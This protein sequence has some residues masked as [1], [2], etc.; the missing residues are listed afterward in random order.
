MQIGKI[1]KVKIRE[2]WKHEQYGF[3]EWLSI[4]ENL[5]ILS[6]KI[7]LSLVEPEKERFIGPYRCD[8]VCKDEETHRVVLIENQ[9]G[10]SNHDHLGKILTYAAG[11]DASAMI[12]IVEN[13]TE[14]HS[15]A[16]AWLN[17]HSDGDIGFYLIKIEAIKIDESSPAPNFIV[18]QQPNKFIEQIKESIKP[19]AGEKFIKTMGERLEFWSGFDKYVSSLSNLPFRKTKAT[20]NAWYNFTIG[21]SKCHIAVSMKK[22]KNFLRVGM[23]ID[24]KAKY[25]EFENNKEKIENA[26]GSALEWDPKPLKKASEIYI[27]VNNFKLGE[28]NTY[29]TLYKAVMDNVLKIYKSFKPFIK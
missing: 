19:E 18:I 4:Q 27:K 11:V 25:S 1:K 23:W 22:Q 12:W 13:P 2:L 17:K 24:D 26:F 3:S 9:F 20:N 21:T 28:V 10:E 16:I 14:E 7:G 29:P 15:N 5:D 6:D 8:I